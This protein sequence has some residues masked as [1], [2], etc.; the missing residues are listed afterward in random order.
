L[1]RAKEQ[2]VYTIMVFIIVCLL[3]YAIGIALNLFASLI[4]TPEVDAILAE[5]T[6]VVLII[7]MYSITFIEK[8]KEVPSE[9]PNIQAIDTIKEPNK[10]PI[11]A[12][13]TV[14]TQKITI[15]YEPKKTEKK[16][17]PAKQPIVPREKL[18]CP[19]CRKDFNKPIYMKGFTI[20]Y[21][22]PSKLPKRIVY[23]PHCD[24]AI[25]LKEKSTLEED[26]W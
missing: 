11:A 2:K 22:S 25:N 21:G 24:Q 9:T 3:F 7:I 15:K 18:M 23:C 16:E 13:P 4:F 26:I 8:R 10:T 12:P 17:Q 5:T 14:N 6:A 1:D 19:A 20:D